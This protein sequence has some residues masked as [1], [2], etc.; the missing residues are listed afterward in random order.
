MLTLIVVLYYRIIF[1]HISITSLTIASSIDLSV[2]FTDF[3]KLRIV[4]SHIFLNYALVG[5]LRPR[6]A[7]GADDGGTRD[8]GGGVAD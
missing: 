3:T 6:P 2:P 5:R 1:F 8:L 4:A 7:G